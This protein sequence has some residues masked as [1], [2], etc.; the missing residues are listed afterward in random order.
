MGTHEERTLGAHFYRSKFL[1]VLEMERV[2][3][4]DE[5]EEEEVEEKREKRSTKSFV[6]IK[7]FH[8]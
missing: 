5:N 7:L 3:V 8:L 6:Y 1:T 4:V 2:E